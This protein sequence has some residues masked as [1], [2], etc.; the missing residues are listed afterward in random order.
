MSRIMKT[1]GA[2]MLALLMI[3]PLSACS[4]RDARA[5]V[6]S[7]GDTT[8]LNFNSPFQD[9]P[10]QPQLSEGADKKGSSTMGTGVGGGSAKK[11]QSQKN[12]SQTR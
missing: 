5:L 1:T 3:M 4:M 7:Q 8:G 12:Y 9:L 2:I 10:D 6:D 11:S